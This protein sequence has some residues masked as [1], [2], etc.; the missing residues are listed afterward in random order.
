MAA[1]TAA[2]SQDADGASPP[3]SATRNKAVRDMVSKWFN[4]RGMKPTDSQA[5]FMFVNIGTPGARRSVTP[6]APR[7]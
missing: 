1:A 7:A 2:I 4:D 5:N 6:A 3:T